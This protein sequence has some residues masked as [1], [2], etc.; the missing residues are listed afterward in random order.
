MQQT[1]QL[2]NVAQFIDPPCQIDD[3]LRTAVIDATPR[4]AFHELVGELLVAHRVGG[5][6]FAEVGR[7]F[8]DRAIV[9][10][11]FDDSR[12]L[13]E[14]RRFGIGMHAEIHT[15]QQCLHVGPIHDFIGELRET[16]LALDEQDCHAKLHTELRLQFVARTMMD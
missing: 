14:T 3:A 7:A 9:Q 12:H 1:S 5:T 11:H 15:L 16:G 2:A 8:E 13:I 4:G 6:A 10:L